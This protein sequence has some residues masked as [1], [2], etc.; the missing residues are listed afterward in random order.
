MQNYLG[1]ATCTC[2]HVCVF[3]FVLGYEY[4]TSSQSYGILKWYTH[5]T[6]TNSRDTCDTTTMRFHNTHI[7]FLIP[8]NLNFSFTY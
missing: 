8:Y 3:K 7:F 4:C 1:Q 2:I 6:I 5:T